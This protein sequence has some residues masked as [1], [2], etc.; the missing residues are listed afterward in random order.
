MEVGTREARMPCRCAMQWRGVAPKGYLNTYLVR[1][2][3]HTDEHAAKNEF[4]T[5]TVGYCLLISLLALYTLRF[6]WTLSSIGNA[7]ALHPP[8]RPLLYAG[9]DICY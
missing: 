6:G 9:S 5:T 3:S 2:T 4:D 8:L 7:S 1:G